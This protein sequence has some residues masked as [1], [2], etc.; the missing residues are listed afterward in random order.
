MNLTYFRPKIKRVCGKQNNNPVNI[1]FVAK[2][3]DIRNL[4]E[5]ITSDVML[6]YQKCNTGISDSEVLVKS[7][8]SRNRTA[9]L[10]RHKGLR[11]VETHFFS[12][13]YYRCVTS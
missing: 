13:G 1:R 7:R 11:K 10:F 6:K 3:S 5:N 8:D 12:Y 4:S 9:P 2:T